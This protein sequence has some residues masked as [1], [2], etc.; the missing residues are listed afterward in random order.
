V[1]WKVIRGHS[2]HH[3]PHLDRTRHKKTWSGL[4]FLVMEDLKATVGELL[5]GIDRSLL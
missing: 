1:I 5:K 3:E 4:M 2:H